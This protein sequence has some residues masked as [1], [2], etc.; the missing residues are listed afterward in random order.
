MPKSSQVDSTTYERHGGGGGGGG[1]ELSPF[2][3][4]R[5]IGE[6]HGSTIR[7][8]GIVKEKA[9]LLDTLTVAHTHLTLWPL[10]DTQ[11][12]AHTCN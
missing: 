8:V 3:I 11:T 4:I 12:A 1:R 5:W 6:V 2:A 7:L 10:M 9:V